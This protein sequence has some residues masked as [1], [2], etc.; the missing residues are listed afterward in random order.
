MDDRVK[1][2]CRF[3]A[4]I[5]AN[6]LILA[7]V[8]FLIVSP[9]V[10]L[11]SDRQALIEQ[12]GRV[13]EQVKSVIAR[14]RTVAAIDPE[15]VEAAAQ[16]FLKGDSESLLSA[17]LLKRLRQI[18]EEEGVSL[19]SVALLPPREWFGRRLVGT[20]I[21]FSGPTDDVVGVISAIEHGSSLFFINHAKLSQMKGVEGGMAEDAVAVTLEIYGATQWPE[22]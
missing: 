15:Q 1:A 17:D 9:T 3:T 19:A 4:F 5:V 8:Y 14:N 22:G 18:A 16:R 13:L 2:W 20:R 7:C 21:E 11:L 6:G 10:R 12:R